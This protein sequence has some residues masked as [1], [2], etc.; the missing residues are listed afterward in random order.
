MMLT[1]PVTLSSRIKFFPVIWLMNLAR[2]EI[3]MF[4]KF[5]VIKFSLL[6]WGSSAKPAGPHPI[7]TAKTNIE[8]NNLI[9][10]RFQGRRHHE[11]GADNSEPSTV[12]ADRFPQEYDT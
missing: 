3:S 4:S 8:N 11:L 12:N 6:R 9:K 10:Q 1:L 2:T 5:I 7:S